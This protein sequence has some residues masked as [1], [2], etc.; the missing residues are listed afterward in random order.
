MGNA[1]Q[2]DATAEMRAQMARHAQSFSAPELLR[3]IRLSTA[4]PVDA[5]SSWQPSL[6][7]EMAFVEALRSAWWL[8]LRPKAA[9]P[10]PRPG[11]STGDRQEQPSGPPG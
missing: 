11:A 3:I 9:P 5:R 10:G 2:V 4:P 8:A 6:P 1:G 7:L